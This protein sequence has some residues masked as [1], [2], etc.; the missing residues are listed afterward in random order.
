MDLGVGAGAARQ[1]PPQPGLTHCPSAGGVRTDRDSD[2]GDPGGAV[3]GTVTIVNR[4]NTTQILATVTVTTGSSIS[5]DR[6]KGGTTFASLTPGMRVEVYY[7]ASSGVNTALRIEASDLFKVSG[8]IGTITPATP[9]GTVLGTL[10]IVN[11]AN[12]SQVL[13]TVTVTT[14]SVISIDRG[15]GGT[16]FASLVSGMRAEVYYQLAVGGV[17]N[18]ALRIEA[19]DLFKVSGLIGTITPATPAGTVLGTL[20]IVSAANTSQVL[21]TVTVTTSSV[22]SIDHGKGGTT[23]ASLVSGMRAEVYYQLA[24]GGVANAALRIE[25]SDI[26]HVTGTASVTLA[27]VTAPGAA[28]TQGSVV[29]TPS[30][31]STPVSLTVPLNIP[32]SVNGVS[33]K[34]LSDIPNGSLVKAVYQVTG[35][36]TGTAIRLET[37]SASRR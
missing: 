25:A 34:A 21:A 27:G 29:I 30:D 36:G 16:T 14:G 10:T 23:F 32:I 4:V 37:G 3:L 5:V 15:K 22:I 18:A 9:A 31:G 8:L 17:T 33:G 20:T 28:T 7:T 19:S 1:G 12:T 2:A 13:A 24:V 11:A 26:L 35:I 6:G